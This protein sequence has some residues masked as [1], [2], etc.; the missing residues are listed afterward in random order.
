MLMLEWAPHTV[1]MCVEEKEDGG[2]EMAQLVKCLKKP[3]MAAGPCNP[4]DG[5]VETEGPLVFTGQSI[6][7]NQ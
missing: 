7:L 2:E 5:E 6:F 1:A 3:G 4:G